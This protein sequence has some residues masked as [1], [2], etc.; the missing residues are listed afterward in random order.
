M[1]EQKDSP[2]DALF[3]LLAHE[4]DALIRGDFRALRK[5]GERKEQLIEDV[6]A[7]QS[8][9]KEQLLALQDKIARNQTL[10]NSALD[11]IRAVSDRMADLQKVRQGLETYDRS[12]LKTRVSTG[13]KS[14]LEKRA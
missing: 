14:A 7:A 6:G 12:G 13:T 4:R 2:V 11:G 8:F 9:E 5:L 10:L 3:S 1:F